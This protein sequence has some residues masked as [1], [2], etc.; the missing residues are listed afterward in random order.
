[1][2]LLELYQQR[3]PF[4]WD[5]P[6]EFAHLLRLYSSEVIKCIFKQNKMSKVNVKKKNKKFHYER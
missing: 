4:Q 1:M 5:H 2:V 3:L 6:L